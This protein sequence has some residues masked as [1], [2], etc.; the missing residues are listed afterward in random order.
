MRK[1]VLRNNFA[2]TFVILLVFALYPPSIN[3]SLVNIYKIFSNKVPD[4]IYPEYP[5]VFNIDDG[6]KEWIESKLKSM[7]LRDKCAQMVMSW[8]KGFSA[9]TASFDFKRISKLVRESKIGGI[10]FFQGEISAE[11][12]MIDELQKASDIPL[13]ISSDFERG[14]GSRVDDAVE[15]PY[16]MA[17]AAT[18]NI[19][20]AY[21]MGRAVAGGSKILGV[22]QNLAPVADVNNNPLNPIINIRSFSEDR[23]IVSSYTIAYIAGSKNER[24]ITT[25]KHFPGHGN[26]QVDSHLD[27]PVIPGSR[28]GLFQNEL[29]PFVQSIKAGVQSVMVGH[30]YVPALQGDSKVPA[31]L[32]KAVVTDLLQNEIEFDGLIITD[33]LNMN[34]VTKYF[35]VADAA[36]MG[37]QA[38]NDIL[39]MPPEDN[40]SIDALVSAV[41]NNRISEERINHSVRKIL[42][43]KRWLKLKNN[44]TKHYPIDQTDSIKQINYS[45]AKDIA[46]HSITLIKNEDNT[47]PVDISRSP[48]IAC[49]TITDGLKTDKKEIFGKLIEGT[50]KKTKSFFIDRRSTG[51]DYSKALRI[52]KISDIIILP[53][54]MRLRSE[55]DSLALAYHEKFIKQIL[56]SKVP[57]IVVSLDDPYLLSALPQAKVY[58]C[59]YGGAEVSQHAAFDAMTGKINFTGKLPISIPNTEF[60]RGFGLTAQYQ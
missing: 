56:K 14:L 31:S 13:L 34:A 39:L 32:S 51:R 58:L 48:K 44:E 47:I 26:T 8:C 60:N 33:A 6:D 3:P 35:S 59:S 29:V 12:E 10:I 54:F 53:V 17:V 9:D 41:N 7:S 11:R 45:L 23:E 27:L 30:L 18:G 22:R 38:G 52:T 25:A 20:Y 4:K 40:L 49:I 57:V 16:N 5:R 28:S 21:E 46:D 1:R 42:A 50:F 2:F 55:N 19:F 43:A 37:V 36:I 15:F 24:V